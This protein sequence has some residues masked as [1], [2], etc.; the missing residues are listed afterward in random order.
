MM[1]PPPT[2]RATP[3]GP[4]AAPRAV[5]VVDQG[6]VLGG[7]VLVACA[8]APG[9]AEA[10]FRVGVAT[11]ADPAIVRS[12]L[13]PGGAIHPLGK[14]YSYQRHSA[15]VRRWA[16][17][18]LLG[19]LR[20]WATAPE[21]LWS[22]L[23]YIVKLARLIV[24][25]RYDLVH[26]NNGLANAAAAWA[27][28]LTGRPFVVH[29]H[30]Y[31]EP[32]RMGRFLARRAGGIIAISESVAASIPAIGVPAERVVTLLNPLTVGPAGSDE[33][34]AQTRLTWGVPPEARVFGIVGRVV[35]WKGQVEF[36][37]AAHQVLAR[38]PDAWAVIIGDGAD[39]S[40]GYGREV[41]ELAESAASE[42]RVVLAGYMGSAARIYAG[43][44]TVVHSSIDP[45][46]FGLVVSEAMATGVPVVASPAG[47]PAELI[48]DGVSG[49]LRDPR[50]HRGVAEAVARLLDPAG[51]RVGII[52]AARTRVAD[53]CDPQRFAAGMAE[54][55]RAA[56]EEAR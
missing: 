5:L 36:L 55:Y 30:G 54:C 12:R 46:P 26:L 6:T 17:R 29:Y 38:D 9:L 42:G 18:G 45:E 13:D 28:L 44:D 22:E 43:L 53:L 47:G 20:L 25:E 27:A 34:R 19:R 24:R 41:V 2:N 16:H 33:D 56:L 50:D 52:Q 4:R 40:D 14:R 21:H 48:E 23:R 10:G 7:S 11:A 51:E 3:D 49:F 8:M 35:R 15:T 31:C 39:G 1:P 37:H 32:T